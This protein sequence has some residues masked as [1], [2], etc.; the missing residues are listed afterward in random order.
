MTLEEKFVALMKNY[1]AMRLQNEEFKNKNEYL[2]CQLSETMKQKR[3]EFRS[4]WSSNS[5]ESD[6]GEENH[7]ES[8]YLNSSSEEKSFS[9][10]N[11]E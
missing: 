1:E 4:S 9:E 8:H 5:S 2:K 3:K 10:A 11:K 7:D 6:Q